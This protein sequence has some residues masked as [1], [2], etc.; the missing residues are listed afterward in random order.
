[1]SRERLFLDTSFVLAWLDPRD[2]HHRRAA[3]LQD[4]VRA[5]PEVWT[6][7]AVLI[8]IG[9]ALSSIDRRNAVGIVKKAYQQD[10]SRVVGVD[11]GLLLQA[12]RLYEARPD[13]T[14][15]LTDCISFIVMQ[16]KG[17]TDALTADRHFVQAGFRALLLE[18]L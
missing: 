18:E 8:E 5:A 3:N 6:T 17:L 2:L 13:K 4:R 15:G 12:L 10:N 7:E 1:M 16:E 11:S 14:W 9:N